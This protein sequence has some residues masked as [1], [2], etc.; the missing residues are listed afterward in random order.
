MEHESGNTKVLPDNA[1]RELAPG[2][3]YVPYIPAKKKVREISPR[4]FIYG[5]SL[6]ILFTF[7]AAYLG[8]LTGNVIEAAIP[9][10]I[11]AVFMGKVL[12]K[13]NPNTIAENVMIQSIGAGSGVVVAGVVFTLPALYIKQLNPNMLHI[14]IASAMGG[15]LGILLLIPLRR[16][17]VKEMHGQLPFPE[18]TA[19]TEILASGE[20][21]GKDRSGIILLVATGIGAL[22]DFLAE[23]VQLWNSMLTSKVL[24]GKHGVALSKQRV[25][26]SIHG[27]AAFMGIGY[28]VG[29]RYA[30]VIAAGSLL[31][32]WVFI[33]LT[34]Y[35]GQHLDTVIPHVPVP[36]GSGKLQTSLLIK[37]MS[38][39]QIFKAYVQ[40]IGVG[41]LA[42]AGFMGIVKMS[43]IIF[44]SFSLG[45]KAIFNKKSVA[46]KTAR[47]DKDM[48]PRLV[49]MAQLVI[50]LILG[51]FY[52]LLVG[53]FTKALI[54]MGI[55]FIF[56]FLF[57]AVAARAIAIV[58]TNP[59][60][61][62]TLMTLIISS[63]ILVAAGLKGDSGKYLA[64]VIGCAVCTA[65]STAGGFITDLK[66]GYW[67]G[68]TPRT[69]QR[70]KFIGILVASLSVGIAMWLLASSY[71]FVKDATHPSPLP[72]PQGNLMATI[73]DAI[74]SAQKL[75]YMLYALGGAI[76]I[77]LEMSKVPALAFALG[78][79]LT[80]HINLGVLVGGFAGWL[81]GRSGKTPEVKQARASQGTLIASGL[82]AG[83]A[84]I[85]IVAAV[86]SLPSL[87]KPIRYLSVG[88]DY[89]ASHGQWVPESKAWFDGAPGQVAGLVMFI[90]LG[91][92]AYLLAR[93]G[94]Q[95]ELKRQAEVN[96]DA[97]KK[98]E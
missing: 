69:Q 38:V 13:N 26:S 19:T 53:S 74:M 27:L 64:L 41:A 28:I 92:G 35:F 90:A 72:S 75:P 54:A 7:A 20:A 52:W 34:Y 6:N 82:M 80:I 30:A 51:I 44:G 98:G 23:S 60:S 66:I 86:L 89:V 73:I 61:G 9:I 67:L 70:F 40:P 24:M 94:A 87:G 88:V 12:H 81:I 15:F 58:G 42:V 56:A 4:V 95:W 36:D 77:I 32:Y 97:K 63:L 45:F 84:L 11:L 3:E 8:L 46:A 33:P 22:F 39:G 25:E 1:Y 17:F 10:A 29:L 31:S 43:R 76:A 18:A 57:T 5:I 50:V 62:M 68:V 79:Y 93:K 49:L 65:L 37:N 78:M 2:E 96:R 85:G 48:D 59:V 47:T 55:T 91:F 71:G 83:A 16:Y 14:I 21:K